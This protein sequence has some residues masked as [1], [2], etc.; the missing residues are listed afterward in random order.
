MPAARSRQK[1][2]KNGQS[3]AQRA[4]REAKGALYRQLVLEAAEA[5]FADKGYDETKMGEVAEASGLSL[6]TLYSVF[7]GKE[8]IYRAVQEQGDRALHSRVL[9]S[10][11]G[12]KDPLQAVLTGLRVT[13]QYFLE[14]PD[15][16]RIRLHGGFTWGTE[17]SAAGDR[18]RSESWRAALEMLR[19]ACERCIADHV[20]VDRDPDLIARMTVSMQQV[21]LAHW[22]E[23][24]MSGDPAQVVA[25]LEAQVQRAFLMAPGAA[26]RPH[27]SG[28]A[29]E[30]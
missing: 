7:P 5:V 24:G 12:L 30:S 22:L 1:P 15:F 9:A 21:E 17:A 19:A 4:A 14:H 27:V 13:T 16:L 3:P 11:E 23:G 26:P 10:T 2:K 28:A 29:G 6:Q 18:E 8:S 20:F 25:E